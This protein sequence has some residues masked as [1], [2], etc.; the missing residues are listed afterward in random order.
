M[1]SVALSDILS[2]AARL[3]YDVPEDHKSD[4]HKLT[5]QLVDA[6]NNVMNQEDYTT[7]VDLNEFPRTDITTVPEDKNPLNG[8]ACKVTVKGREGGPLSG[9]TI[10]LKDNICLAGVPCTFG[11]NAVKDFIPTIDATI[12]TRILEAGGTIVGKATC[13]NMS[14]GAA[15]FTACNGPVHNPRAYGFSTG[16]SSSGCGALIGSGEVDMG[17]GGDQGGSIRLPAACCGVVGLKATFGLIP[18][19]GVLPSEPSIDHTG[20]MAASV[21]DIALLLEAIAGY[22]GIDDR[23][24]G[25]PACPLVPKYSRELHEARGKGLR[26]VKIGVLKEGLEI[27]RLQPEVR[28]AVEY[29][30]T[31]YRK[32]GAE[33]E[34]VSVPMHTQVRS[35]TLIINRVGSKQT[36]LGRQYGRR[37]LYINE[38]FEKLLPWTQATW[39]CVHSF[40]ISTSLCGEYVWEHYPTVY[41]RS[42]NLVRKAKEQYD[43]ALAKYDVLIMPTIGFGA[44]RNPSSDPGPWDAAQRTADM[45][46]NTAQFNATGHPA[47]SI[48]IGWTCPVEEDILQP[49]D[50]NIKLPVGLQI[51]GSHFGEVMV[52]RVGDAFE[53]TVDWKTVG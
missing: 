21:E 24:L 40:V 7:P 45:I 28:T 31:T 14:H 1:A 13:E 36:R 17:M 30:I 32:L 25:C 9:R 8:W 6:I 20:P 33:V 5:D 52:L 23:Q 26:G 38:Y 2:V 50:K 18:Y 29:A 19:T 4:Y 16:G 12:A 34:E 37:G 15:S 39:D 49:E 3:G 53:Q 10:C 22:D 48:P 43:A 11:T 27:P 51:V 47:L 44:R 42:V 35:A 41:G 46:V